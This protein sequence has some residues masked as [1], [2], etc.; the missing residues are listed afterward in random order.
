MDAGVWVQA[1]RKVAAGSGASEPLNAEPGS[2]SSSAAFVAEVALIG[3]FH[4]MDGK[5][6]WCNFNFDKRLCSSVKD[7]QVWPKDYHGSSP[8]GKAED[9]QFEFCRAGRRHRSHDG[10]TGLLAS[11][12]VWRPYS[13]VWRR[14]WMNPEVAWLTSQSLSFAG[15]KLGARLM[16]S[17]RSRLVGPIGRVA[18]NPHHVGHEYQRRADEDRPL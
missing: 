7:E 1:L 13:V 6:C 2:Q 4:G 14:I 15:S 8:Q 5:G 17:A 10:A 11:V 16:L 12:R 3:A 9:Q 18:Q